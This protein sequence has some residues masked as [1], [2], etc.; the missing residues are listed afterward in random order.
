VD[1]ESVLVSSINWNENSP[2][3]NREVGVV[4]HDEKVAGYFADVFETDWNA[5]TDEDEQADADVTPTD[6]ALEIIIIVVVSGIGIW[7][8]RREI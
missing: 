1:G 7:L 3:N 5:G 2:K 8:V 4:V 6:Y